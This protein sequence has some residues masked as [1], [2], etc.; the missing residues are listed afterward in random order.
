MQD[1]FKKNKEEWHVNNTIK[2]TDKLSVSSFTKT[3][4]G[5]KVARE[6]MGD[7]IKTSYNTLWSTIFVLDP[8]K[9]VNNEIWIVQDEEEPRR[10][11]Q[12]LMEVK[13]RF[14]KRPSMFDSVT[15]GII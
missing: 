13:D 4:A 9:K 14:L 2:V 1:V 6:E 3:S 5:K 15:P 8:I 12:Y 10:S 11:I 7:V